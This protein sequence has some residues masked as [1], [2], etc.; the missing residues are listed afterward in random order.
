MAYFLGRPGWCPPRKGVFDMPVKSVSYS[1]SESIISTVLSLLII[2]IALAPQVSRAQ[3]DRAVARENTA[4]DDTPTIF[5]VRK[6]LP[7]EPTDPTFHDFYI[8]AGVEAGFKKGQYLP[9]ARAIPIHDPVQNKQQGIL[10]VPVGKVLVIHVERNMTV[11]RLASEL[12]DDERPT[13]EYEAIMIGDRVDMKGITTEAPK[14]TGKKKKKTTA[15]IEDVTAIVSTEAT[16]APNTSNAPTDANAPVGPA[17]AKTL[18]EPAP[19]AISPVKSDTAAQPQPILESPQ[20]SSAPQ[21][22]TQPV[23]PPTA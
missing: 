10:N 4:A 2:F 5:D 15:T 13:L 12:G 20:R 8:N 7:M 11:A 19:N 14:S 16:F 9:V 17:T 1:L 23:P 3:S 6:S 22:V 21:R 18:T